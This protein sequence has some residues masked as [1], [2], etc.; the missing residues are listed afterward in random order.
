MSEVKELNVKI[1]TEL[2]KKVLDAVTQI[3]NEYGLIIKKDRGKFDRVKW[4]PNITIAV[5]EEVAMSNAKS[6]WDK[7]CGNLGLKPSHF[8]CV[9]VHPSGSTFKICGVKPNARKN[10]IL[11]ESAK[12]AKYVMPHDEVVGYLHGIQKDNQ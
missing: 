7:H 6:Q 10:N 12:G 2:S 11:I 1:V 9:F 4:R 5:P 8:G 3:A